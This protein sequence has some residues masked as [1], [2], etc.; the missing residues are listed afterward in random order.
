[1]SLRRM[2]LPALAFHNKQIYGI[3]RQERDVAFA[4]RGDCSETSSLRKNGLR[5]EKLVRL[6]GAGAG[7]GQ[8]KAE[9]R[10]VT[11]L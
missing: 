4:D 7:A 1:M 2:I 9:M 11:F 8:D 10:Q 6:I 5:V 3:Y